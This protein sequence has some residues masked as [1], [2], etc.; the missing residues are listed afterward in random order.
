MLTTEI[1]DDKVALVANKDG[2]TLKNYFEGIVPEESIKIDSNEPK[3][4][5]KSVVGELPEREEVQDADD[6]I[7]FLMPTP[8]QL[9]DTEKFRKAISTYHLTQRI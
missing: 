1:K 8:Q 9:S 4:E 3:L 5:D 2:K 7:N 6:I